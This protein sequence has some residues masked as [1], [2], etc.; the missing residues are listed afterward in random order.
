MAA[1]SGTALASVASGAA[2][3]VAPTGLV[4]GA[5]VG[6]LWALARFGWRRGFRR[7]RREGEG[8]GDA[9]RD[10]RMDAQG[11]VEERRGGRAMRMGRVDVW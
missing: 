1:V 8:E 6:V 3:L 2:F 9:R 11:E 4:G 5:G 10:E 7:A